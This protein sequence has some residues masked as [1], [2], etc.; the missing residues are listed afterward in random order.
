MKLKTLKDLEFAP[1]YAGDGEEHYC[2]VNQLKT[3]AIKWVKFTE[4]CRERT[5]KEPAPSEKDRALFLAMMDGE[6]M[7][8]TNF[9]NIT[10]EDLK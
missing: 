5:K 3:E 1:P 7:V 8:L 4:E 10:E 2:Y 9:F 6:I